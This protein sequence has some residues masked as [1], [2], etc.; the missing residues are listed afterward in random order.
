MNIQTNHNP[1]ESVWAMRDNRPQMFQI[2][3]INIT[4]DQ[5]SKIKIEYS[6]SGYR[7][8]YL[9]SLVSENDCKKQKEELLSSL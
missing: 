4:I 2:S 5:H 6:L 8:T 9:E 7:K 3:G 1:G